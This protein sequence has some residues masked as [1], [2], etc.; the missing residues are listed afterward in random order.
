MFRRFADATVG[1][2]SVRAI[3]PLDGD[4]AAHDGGSALQARKR[5]IVF[6]IQQ[7][8]NLGAAQSPLRGSQ[9]GLGASFSWGSLSLFVA[10]TWVTGVEET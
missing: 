7:S 8:I 2:V 10:N 4:A 1:Q 5:N 3:H 6:G 9:D